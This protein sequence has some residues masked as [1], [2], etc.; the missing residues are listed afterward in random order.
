MLH[1]KSTNS[2]R[3]FITGLTPATLFGVELVRPPMQQLAKLQTAALKAAG[4]R[5][6]GVPNSVVFSLAQT[7]LRDP[8]VVALLATRTNIMIYKNHY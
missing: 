4:L 8:M 3:V 1:T 7:R 5:V 2:S 6:Y